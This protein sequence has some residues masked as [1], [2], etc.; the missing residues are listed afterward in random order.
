[1]ADKAVDAIATDLWG[2]TNGHTITANE[3]GKGRVFWGKPIAEVLAALQTAEDFV[4]TKPNLNTNLSWIRRKADADDI[5]FVANQQY[6]PE[7]LLVRFRVADKRPE[8]WHSDMGTTSPVSYTIANGF[9]T[10]PLA[11]DPY[12]SVFVVFRERAN[13]VA[14]ALT[15]TKPTVL[16]PIGGTW[17]VR[18]PNL[19]NNATTLTMNALQSWPTLTDTT[20]RYFSGTATYTNTFLLAKKETGKQLLLD[21]GDVKEIAE[22]TLNGRPLGILWKTPFR[23]EITDAATAGKNTLEIR[24]TNL[25]TNCMEGDKNLPPAYRF[26]FATNTIFG[27]SL[28]G[29]TIALIPSGL[30]G[31]VQ[32]LVR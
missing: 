12:G 26:T 15:E 14:V 4:C 6:Q 29:P 16:Q 8:L 7:N 19:F 30:L 10:V 17:Q 25:W 5:Y 23:T 20:L 24:V 13:Q 3:Y 11:L 32:I 27:R 18:F 2:M 1:M 9:T 22:V 28:A 31:P 21:L